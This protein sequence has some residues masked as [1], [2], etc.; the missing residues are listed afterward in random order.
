MDGQRRGDAA[1]QLGQQDVATGQGREPRDTVAV[2]AGGA[3]Q[4]A[5]D[6]DRAE[7]PNRVQQALCEGRLIG[8]A[9]RDRR[10]D[11]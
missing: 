2:D 5:A 10:W 11:P 1:G 7:R 3:D 6:G 9:E 4:A 8:P